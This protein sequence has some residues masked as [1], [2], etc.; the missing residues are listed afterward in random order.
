MTRILGQLRGG[1]ESHEIDNA[2][3]IRR[4]GLGEVPAQML[5]TQSNRGRQLLRRHRTARVR[6]DHFPRAF[7]ERCVEAKGVGRISQCLAKTG[8]ERMRMNEIARGVVVD[9]ID[10]D[11]DEPQS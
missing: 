3:E 6:D 10:D 4:T 8:R 9:P 5:A 1:D 7:L 2:F 11:I